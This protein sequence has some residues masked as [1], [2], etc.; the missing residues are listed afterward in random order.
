MSKSEA[1]QYVI[2]ER[3]EVPASQGGLPPCYQ[4]IDESSPP[5]ESSDLVGPV[6]IVAALVI[7]TC[8]YC[9]ILIS[10]F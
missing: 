10:I 8:I 2:V 4:A 7:L 3:T 9:D 5:M 6:L 1:Q